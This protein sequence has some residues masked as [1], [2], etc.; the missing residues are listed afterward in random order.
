V[1]LPREKASLAEFE[2]HMAKMKPCFVMLN[3]HGSPSKIAGHKNGIILEKGRNEKVTKGAIVYAR[4][5]FALKELG[6]A[7]VSS[8]AK[9]FV[10]Y[11]FPFMFVSDPNR[12]AHPMKDEL[13]APCRI[14]SNMIPVSIIKGQTIS[15]AVQKAKNTMDELI[16]FW[17]TRRDLPEASIVASC[18]YWNK[19][20]LGL[21][22]EADTRIA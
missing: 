19:L 20:G 18:L 11:S 10:S 7:C 5:C 21:R 1:N 13:A 17:E 9:G 4:S 22:G 3:G 16:G 12:S 2:G 6:E 15:E 14:T 8:G